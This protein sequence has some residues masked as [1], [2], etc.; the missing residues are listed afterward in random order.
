MQKKQ[1]QRIGN[2]I[3]N[4]LYILL[5]E[6]FLF[7]YKVFFFH[8][9]TEDSQRIHSSAVFALYCDFSCPAGAWEDGEYKFQ[10]AFGQ[11][12]KEGRQPDIR[13]VAGILLPWPFPADTGQCGYS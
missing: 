1:Y 6:L 9:P 12:E 11:Y 2:V 13:K 8:T 5:N 7:Q 4:I 3:K 10:R